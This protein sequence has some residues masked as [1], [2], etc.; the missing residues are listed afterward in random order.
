[1]I[2]R[3]TLFYYIACSILSPVRNIRKQRVNPTTVNRDAG[4]DGTKVTVQVEVHKRLTV[5]ITL[6]E[7]DGVGGNQGILK[8]VVGEGEVGKKGLLERIF[9]VGG[10]ERVEE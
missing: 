9:G 6:R 8:V 4:E 2:T 1:M 10:R 7:L 3:A 5:H